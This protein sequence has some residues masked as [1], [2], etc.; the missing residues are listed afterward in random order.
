MSQIHN[1]YY[2]DNNDG[3]SK[4]GCFELVVSLLVGIPLAILLLI[5]AMGM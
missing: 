4:M 3:N 5:Y 2:G 1:H